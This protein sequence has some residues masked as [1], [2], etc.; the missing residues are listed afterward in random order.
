MSDEP[1]YKMVDGQL[2]ELTEHEKQEILARWEAEEEKRSDPLYIYE[3]RKT[4]GREII[5]QFF[6][7]LAAQESSTEKLEWIADHCT[8]TYIL[9][10]NGALE[11]AKVKIKAMDLSYKPLTEGERD[12][13]VGLIDEALGLEEEE[14]E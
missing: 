13:L 3:M 11:T 10:S 2:V 6:K 5:E 7:Y 8:P 14:E 1:Q 12:Y 9:M 4:Q